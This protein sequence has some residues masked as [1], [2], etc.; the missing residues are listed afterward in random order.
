MSRTLLVPL[1]AG[2]VAGGCSRDAPP[3]APDPASIEVVVAHAVAQVTM[4]DQVDDALTR[5]L[6]ALGPRGAALQGPLLRL[7]ARPK[8]R[9]ALAEVERALDALAPTMPSEYWPDLDALRLELGI[10]FLQ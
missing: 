5:L 7:Q 3:L 10:A 6:P 4:A 9:A 8:D 2:V 1:I